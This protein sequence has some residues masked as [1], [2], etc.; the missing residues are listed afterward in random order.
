[1]LI[2]GSQSKA[3]YQLLRAYNAEIEVR[4][5][6]VDE[7]FL[8]DLSIEDNVKRTAKLK[9]EAIIKTGLQSDDILICADTVV[10]VN[11]QILYKPT[12][13]QEAL[14]MIAMFSENKVEII[15]GV[16]L[17]FA[18]NVYNFSEKSTVCFEKITPKQAQ[19]YLDKTPY[20]KNISGALDINTI[21]EYTSYTYEGSFSNIIGLPMET[22]SNYL[23]DAKALKTV[24]FSTEKIEPINIYRS[25]V[26]TFI[27][28]AEQILLLK[29][30]TYDKKYTFYMS[31]G[32][33]YHNFENREEVIK[34]EA[35]EEAGAL[36]SN[37]QYLT[38]TLEY[39][40][41][42]RYYPYVKQ[43]VHSYYLSEYKDELPITYIEYEQELILGVEMVSLEKA[44][45]L[46][47]NQLTTFK[48]LLAYPAYQMAECD[49]YALNKLKELEGI[50]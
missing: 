19:R 18:K 1:M 38:S 44:L 49:L 41:L 25:S 8:T 36:I 35:Q 5:T 22:I 10:V 23:Y 13:Y 42:E 50:K 3:R 28:K 33:G 45:E 37:L 47:Q 39:V 17:S 43:T 20:Y 26:R 12:D 21:H 9:A 11:Q 6:T 4:T 29:A 40:S 7:T 15:T 31:I 16:Y 46:Y 2:L 32:G 14:E 30:Y 48:E 24:E 34:K 27:K